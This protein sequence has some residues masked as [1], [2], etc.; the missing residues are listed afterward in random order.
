MMLCSIAPLS[1]FIGIKLPGWLTSGFLKADATEE[2]SA[3]D[4]KYTLDDSDLV[5]ITKYTGSE[6]HLK[7]PN[8]IDGHEV[9]T[10]GGWAFSSNTTLISIDIPDTV[11]QVSEVAFYKCN[12]LEKVTGLT[13]VEAIREMAFANCSSLASFPKLNKIKYLGGYAFANASSLTSFYIPKSL[14][15]CTLWVNIIGIGTY[16]KTGIFYNSGLVDVEFE[17][18]I[19]SLPPALFVDCDTLTEIDIPDTVTS[20][21]YACFYLS[22]NLVKVN[23]IQNV[24]IIED[25]AF[26]NTGLS[27]IPKLKRLSSLGAAAF[28]DTSLTYFYVPKTL[29][30]VGI[31]G[32]IVGI[33]SYSKGAFAESKLKTIEFEE[34]IKY[35]PDVLCY[36]AAL[37]E[38]VAFP[39]T[40]TTIGNSSFS[41]CSGLSDLA[42]GHSVETINSNAFKGCSSLENVVI[43]SNVSFL[44]SGSFSQCESL[45]S[46]I[47]ENDNCVLEDYVFELSPLLESVKLPANM[48][49]L[50]RGL[51]ADCTALKSFTL[52]SQ[53]TS[54]DDSAFYNCDS[55]TMVEIP[56]DVQVV[57][58][59]AFYGCN[60]LK[61]VTMGDKV[62]YIGPSAFCG[63]ELLESIY[64]S[65]QLKIIE[66]SCFADCSSLKEFEVPH[67]L[68]SGVSNIKDS[69]FK[70]CTSLEKIIIPESVS[71]IGSS[72]LSYPDKTVIYGCSGSYAETY[73]NDN[74]FTFVDITKHITG[75]MLKNGTSETL[76]IT[77][78]EYADAEF[79]YLPEDTTD[80]ISLE[81]KDTN[82]AKIIDN[83]IYGN[84]N[85][86]AVI[87]AS[88]T[89]G[90]NYDFNV[91]VHSVESIEITKLPDKT[92]YNYGEELDTSGMVVSATYNDGQTL[93]VTDYEVN[94]YDS[95]KYSTQTLTVS[96][97]GRQ[98]TFTVNVVDARVKVVSIEVTKLPKTVYKI[99]EGL[100]TAGMVVT[101]TYSDG[102][103]AE[104][105]DYKVSLLNTMKV[106]QQTITVSYHEPADDKD[107]TTSFTVTVGDVSESFTVDFDA[108]GGTVTPTRENVEDGK[109]I[110]LP[111]PSYE[112][113]TFNGWNTSSDGKG[114][115]YD[116]GA[117]FKPT[118]NITFYAQWKPI[119][120]NIYNLGEETYGFVNY[121]DD[122]SPFGHCFGMSVTSAGY[123]N[124]ELDVSKIGIE[125]S[126]KLN[127]VTLN[128]TVKDNI[129][130]YQQIQGIYSNYAIV[131]GGTAYLSGYND[132]IEEYNYYDIEKD[133]NECIDYI[134]GHE[135]DGKGSLQIGFRQYRNGGHAIN[136]LRYEEVDGQQRIYAYDNNFPEI[137]TYFYKDDNG[138]IMQAPM[139]TFSGSIDCITLRSIDK[140]F[141]NAKAYDR[142]R[143]IYAKKD[144]IS[145]EGSVVYLME[146]SSGE[147]MMFEIPKGTDEVTITPLT[148][149][150][151]FSYCSETCSFGT[152]DDG[153]YGVL[154]VSA[155]GETSASDFKVF[156]D[157][158]KHNYKS[159]VTTE[160]TCTKEGI[161][162]YTC[163]CGDSYTEKIPAVGHK[164]IWE[165]NGDGTETQKCTVCGAI[166]NT[167]S[168]NAGDITVNSYS[169]TRTDI[170]Y[171]QPAKIIASATGLP[172]GYKLAIYEGDSQKKA[173]TA[174][175]AGEATV[176]FETGA[177]TV[178][179]T[180]T[181]KV[182]DASGKEV[183]GKSKTI[184]IDV[185]DGFFQKII[186][187]FLKLFGALKLVEIK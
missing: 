50:T 157:S 12:N 183:D 187:F 61:T 22:D 41:Y 90:L 67:G 83:R 96:Y 124:K 161:L 95:Q 32:S 138:N 143:F 4:Y 82:I 127:T 112:G 52:P 166:G 37:L 42:L 170:K 15:T 135:Y 169:G 175:D 137:E 33:G 141:D 10:I 164:Y 45:K 117:S 116:A 76:T 92:S 142:L 49:S 140:Y 158:H 1:G 21:G 44:G 171:N 70:N 11:T 185:N 146:S 144:S 36:D 155:D 176:E 56:E 72:C 8:K 89:G 78:G 131:A 25:L 64:V 6:A 125:S 113:F 38:N 105:T 75:I 150:A 97:Y 77:R 55:L 40:V 172:K 94:G 119:K 162:T 123:Y 114:T 99:G 84:S 85:G 108:N 74:G 126:D 91:L 7:I 69:A 154:K 88:T 128:E 133:W 86:N 13:N 153:T 34:G 148:D 145:V 103:S 47:V 173:V 182:L 98:T 66:S 167:R 184:T 28:Y 110:V 179:R 17:N 152:I 87:T 65:K 48:K 31:N 101:A 53:I 62:T 160:P 63:C 134:K 30:T 139:S 24:E 120:E 104:I 163:E 122:D 159:E 5:T 115:S 151:E 79:N 35:V 20:I 177:V 60:G 46:V 174:N 59:Q 111:V 58:R 16:Y 132:D 23:G 118:E 3:G 73:A 93:D 29:K 54:I 68:L 165:D 19:T 71:E 107:I 136:F 180:F 2:L 121:G 39:D 9:R 106:G 43:P 102:T 109:S 80:I 100:D 147:Y 149:N 18:G 186:S 129:C 14:E 57:A 27:V 130:H 178:D 26:C 168:K 51:F 156:N 81:S 181:V